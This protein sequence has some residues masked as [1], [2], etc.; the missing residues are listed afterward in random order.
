VLPKRTLAVRPLLARLPFERLE[1]APAEGLFH[2][3]M[4]RVAKP[5][6]GKYSYHMGQLL[7][8]LEV[9]DQ[10]PWRMDASGE[11]LWLTVIEVLTDSS[12]RVR[13]PDGAV[14]TLTDSERCTHSID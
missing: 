7:T 11:P 9:G 14:E 10:L 3:S 1:R 4:S 13:F 6:T 2:I 12:Y 8:L 5:T